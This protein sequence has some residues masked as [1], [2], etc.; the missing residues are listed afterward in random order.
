MARSQS[1]R[2]T[3]ISSMLSR[4]LGF[5]RVIFDCDMTLVRVEGI[6]ELARLKG[7]AE[8][9][10]DLTQQAMNGKLRLEEVYAKRLELLRPT[11][12]ELEEIGRIYRRSLSPQASEVVSALQLAGV[13]VFIVSGGL[14]AAVLDLAEYLKVPA[15]N[16]HAVSVRLDE[17]SGTW[18]EYT[19][20]QYA[21]NPDE[22]YFAFAPTPLSESSGKSAVVSKLAADGKRTMMVGD[23]LTDL[24]TKD[25]VRLFVGFGGVER[26]AAVE[27][28]AAVFLEGPGLAGLLPIALSSYAVTKLTGTSFLDIFHD[29]VRAIESGQVLFKDDAY[30]ERILHAHNGANNPQQVFGE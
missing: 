15:Q 12:A 17:L 9:I 21:G 6:D 28:E 13:E 19:R 1:K 8:Y 16:V 3:F 24:V 23:G 30:R 5:Q 22:T 10:A 2:K 29:G 14:K 11:R 25:V 26:R 4:H 27:E 18:W 7:Q 20:H